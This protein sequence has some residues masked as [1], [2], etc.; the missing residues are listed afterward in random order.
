MKLYLLCLW[1]FVGMSAVF[2]QEPQLSFDD[3]GKYIYYEV[4]SAKGKT[5]EELKQ[6]AKAYFKSLAAPK[7]Q[8]SEQDSL[9]TGKGK[10]ILHKT[11]F[12]LTRPTGEVRYQL[13]LDFKEGK[14]RFW[15]TDF[16]F[17]PYQR[18]R[19][20]NFVPATP[21]GIPLEQRPGK[22]NAA[23]WESYG[24][25]TAKEA[26][27][28]ADKFKRAMLEDQ[29]ITIPTAKAIPVQTTKDKKW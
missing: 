15:L 6:G 25:A 7:I 20:G 19:Y 28:F 29:A 1:C 11:A 22:L 17:V 27:L 5:A 24:K 23:E 3:R 10:L 18:D 4:V 2:A 8:L 16:S 26:Q 21:L 14:Y 12:V 9:W 13:Y